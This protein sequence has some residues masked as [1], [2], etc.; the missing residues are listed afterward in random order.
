MSVVR[1]ITDRRTL[2]KMRE[3][4]REQN[5]RNYL[6]FRI[7]INLG[8]PLAD[9]L[10]LRLEEIAGKEKFIFGNYRI[11]ICKSLQREIAFFAGD[12]KEGWL[13]KSRENQPLSRY[14]L[15]Q[16]IRTAAEA[17]NF[18]EPIGALTLRKTF[19]YW[20]YKENHIYLPALSKY[21]GHHTISQTL[22]YI[23][24]DRE[25]AEEIHLKEM[26]L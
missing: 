12:R 4:L 19:A 24:L 8:L 13:F 14:H 2:E 15:Y 10:R 5:I 18:K 1:P 16:M 23:G 6:I 22:K 20:S 11:H 21:L 9:L 26:D 3:Y 25:E 7:G 17:A